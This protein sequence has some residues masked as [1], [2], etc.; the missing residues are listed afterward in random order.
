VVFET[1]LDDERRISASS[2]VTAISREI[3]WSTPSAH[4]PHHHLLDLDDK[5]DGD[6]VAL[7]NTRVNVFLDMHP[8]R[9]NLKFIDCLVREHDSAGG[10]KSHLSTSPF[11]DTAKMS[12]HFTV[13][14]LKD[15]IFKLSKIEKRLLFSSDIK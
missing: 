12:D 10:D 13:R 14:E 1:L 11:D 5:T 9:L 15:L 3:G 8:L 6:W 7:D 4:Y 2:N